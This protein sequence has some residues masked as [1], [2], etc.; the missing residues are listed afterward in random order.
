MTR[1]RGPAALFLMLQGCLAHSLSRT[2]LRAS[3]VQGTWLL[4][5][6]WPDIMRPSK[7]HAADRAAAGPRPLLSVPPPL[8]SGL[9]PLSVSFLQGFAAHPHRQPHS[10]EVSNQRVSLKHQS[11]QGLPARRPP[12]HEQNSSWPPSS[13]TRDRHLPSHLLKTGVPNPRQVSDIAK[14]RDSDVSCK[15]QDGEEARLWGRLA[16]HNCWKL[17]CDIS[18]TQRWLRSRS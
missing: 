3:H 17:L 16:C 6:S 15:W 18:G 13:P 7:A 12:H 8:S 11:V 5:Q 1:A 9:F 14:V 2:L 10:D 4:P